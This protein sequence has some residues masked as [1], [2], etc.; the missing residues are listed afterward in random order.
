MVSKSNLGLQ[1]FSTEKCPEQYYN[2]CLLPAEERSEEDKVHLLKKTIAKRTP[3]FDW[4][5]V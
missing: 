4:R 1:L 5:F 3:S 2:K